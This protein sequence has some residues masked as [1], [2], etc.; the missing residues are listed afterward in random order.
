[1]AKI[2][3][4]WVSTVALALVAEVAL[5]EGLRHLRSERETRCS[6]D[7]PPAAGRDLTSDVEE[8]PDGPIRA[9]SLRAKPG[10]SK[11]ISNAVAELGA[12]GSKHQR[13]R[14]MAAFRA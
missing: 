10:R 7:P 8:V 4:V 9:A 1:M 14:A 12:V 11:S 2:P 6:L 13:Q 5:A 3:V